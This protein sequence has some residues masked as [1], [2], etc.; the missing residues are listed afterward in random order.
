M[1]GIQY[2]VD[3][4]LCIDATGSMGG[5]IDQAKTNALQFYEDL[6]NAMSEKDKV[7]DN[8][9]VKVIAFRD[10]YV[11]GENSMIESGFFSLPGEAEDFAAFVNPLTAHGGG[12]DP[13]T[14]LEALSLAI[15][16]D[17][18]KSGDRRR[19]IIVVWTDASV[20]PL[21]KNVESKPSNYPTDLPKNFDE[22]TDLWEGQEYM[23]MAAKRIII[24][25]PDAS[26]WTDIATHWN[27][28]IHYPSK[29]GEGL[30]EV[31]YRTILDA[32]AN[33]V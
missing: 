23:N 16:S 21:E 5:L 13:E 14:G 19:Q 24:Y 25:A 8:L 33:S 30:S 20:H 17:W 2:S 28:S 9:R 32:I 29:A 12:D 31:D 26:G 3:I 11:D 1:Q 7:V 4:V 27:N 22:L 15:K 6:S 18:S 10:Y